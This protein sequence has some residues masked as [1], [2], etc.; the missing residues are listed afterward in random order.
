MSATATTSKCKMMTTDSYSGS[1]GVCVQMAD[2]KE[3]PKNPKNEK[4][5]N[6]KLNYTAVV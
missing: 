1:D 6:E 5:K 4:M 2:E 3:N